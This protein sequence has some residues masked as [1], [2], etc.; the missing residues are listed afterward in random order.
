MR[1]STPEILQRHGTGL[2]FPWQASEA[3]WIMGYMGARAAS[4]RSWRIRPRWDKSGQTGA[5]G[6]AGGTAA[7]CP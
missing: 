2:G 6:G 1:L 7:L 3:L 4:G 5:D